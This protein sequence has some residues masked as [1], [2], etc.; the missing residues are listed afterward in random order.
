MIVQISKA[1]KAGK[2]TVRQIL[3]ASLISQVLVA[4]GLMGYF[5]WRN[6][7]KTVEELALRLSREVT[8]HINK[9]IANYLDTPATFLEI[10]RV[11]A[12]SSGLNIDSIQS[13]KAIFWQQTQIHPYINTLYFG[14][15][16]GDFIEIEI[17]DYPKVS[18]RNSLTAPDRHIYNLDENGKKISLITTEKYDP[19]LRPWYIAAKKYDDLV[20][21]PIY[22]FSDPP[23]LGITP[24]VP[25]KDP[26]TKKLKGVMA[27]DLT[28]DEI[29]N[30]LASLKISNSGRVFIIEKSGEM[31]AISTSD[32]LVKQSSNGNQ[33]IHYSNIVDPLVRVTGKFL[34]NRSNN[35]QNTKLLRQLIF[36]YENS[37]HFVQTTSIKP[38]PGLNWLVVTVIPEADFGSYIR[39]NTY[40]TLMLSIFSLISA[41]FLGAIANQWIVRSVKSLR[42]KNK[43]LIYLANIDGLTQVYNR[44][45]FNLA[46]ERL[47]KE[48]INDR[49][50]ISLILCDVDNFKLYNDHYGHLNG[51]QCLKKVAQA[52]SAEISRSQDI[53]A[54]YGGEEFAII[55]PSTEAEGALYV[56]R[57]INTAVSNLQI[58]HTHSMAENFITISCGVASI[59]P[60]PNIA[61]I[62]LIDSADQA[63]YK[64][65]RMGRNCCIL[66]ELKRLV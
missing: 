40:T 13:L 47:W 9:H 55:F 18:I 6:G 29:S 34:E 15:E 61:Y 26:E 35:F 53:V 38:Y 22:L 16:T 11:F 44:Y 39:K 30:F 48:A 51:D 57:K 25:L 59:V 2:L 36:K 28:L 52:I 19:R 56:A 60:S 20:W 43:E 49:K 4:V 7:R 66:G 21:S 23:V 42:Q 31:V 58:P 17:K 8:S 62:N 41:T 50:S 45:Y 65:K 12:N 54:R 27:I 64:A 63:L 24:V 14:S 46:L 37:R 32:S 33:R 5:S 3:I 10:N 1:I